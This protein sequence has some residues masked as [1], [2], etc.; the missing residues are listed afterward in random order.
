MN[1]K[2]NI[3][4]IFLLFFLIVAIL[5]ST[6]P[7]SETVY[8]AVPKIATPATGSNIE[9]LLKKYNPD[10][11][12]IVHNNRSALNKWCT[13]FS[14][15]SMT[16][17][18][19]TIVHET[20]HA[21][22][23]QK[24]ICSTAT[25]YIGNKKNILLPYYEDLYPTSECTAAIPQSL[26]TSHFET[27][28]GNASKNV[29]NVFGLYGL[30]YEFAAHYWGLDTMSS[31]KN[32]YGNSKKGWQN[33]VYSLGNNMT[34]Y[35]ECKYWMLSYMIYA[36]EYY[37]NL[38]KKIINDGIYCRAYE[39]MEK[40]FSNLIDSEI[41]S[42]KCDYPEIQYSLDGI[43]YGGVD[44]DLDDYSAIQ[45]ELKKSKYVKMDQLLR[46][47]ANAGEKSDH[48]SDKDLSIKRKKFKLNKSTASIKTGDKLDL[49]I[50]GSYGKVKWSSKNPNIA[51]VNDKGVVTGKKA[52][53]TVITVCCSELD[54]SAKCT[55][56]VTKKLSPSQ[57]T[58]KILKLKNQYPEG[59]HWTNE[60][61]YYYWSATS[62]GC[63]GCIAL[64][65]EV[66]DKIF[67]KNASIIRHTEFDQIKP[68]DHIRIGDYHSVI[69]VSKN[70][71][72]LTIVEG[73]YNRSVHW[74]RTITRDQLEAR[75]F[76]VETRY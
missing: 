58:K 21:N 26:R 66:S 24:G 8:A 20:Y 42:L 55:I 7:C 59:M 27:Y 71:N 60:D 3:G 49:K 64:A 1:N 14:P 33:Y 39:I 56:K 34:A 75:S 62:C 43:H 31:L 74:G 52:G 28:V 46:V 65:A 5:V 29:S 17:K 61:N 41:K 73:N 6:L 67:G 9:S 37:P 2:A 38:Y 23:L 51:T 16:D 12:Y 19:D 15:D 10:S 50:N 70:K 30:M 48:V 68:G 13:L 72:T 18:L 57:V 35:A 53:Q 40:K 11:Y 47:N 63:Y 22:T 54:K 25:I 32:Y 76:Y 4:K 36:R 45:E 69:V 44:F